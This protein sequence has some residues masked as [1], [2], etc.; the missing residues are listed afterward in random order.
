M[1]ARLLKNNAIVT[2]IAQDIKTRSAFIM[3]TEH[4]GLWFDSAEFEFTDE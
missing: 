1:K 3:L 2:V 4:F